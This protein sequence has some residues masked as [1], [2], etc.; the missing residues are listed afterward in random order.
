MGRAYARV[1]P[2]GVCGCVFYNNDHIILLRVSYRGRSRVMFSAIIKTSPRI[3]YII[4]IIILCNMYLGDYFG[5]RNISANDRRTDVVYC[6]PVVPAVMAVRHTHSRAPKRR[7][8]PPH[9]LRVLR[10]V[11]FLLPPPIVRPGTAKDN[12]IKERAATTGALS[13]G[14]ICVSAC[15]RNEITRRRNNGTQRNMLPAVPNIIS[16]IP[17]AL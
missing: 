15:R 5:R 11:F 7:R 14:T 8:P 2:T 17:R 4:T 9:T 1:R 10:A 12:A 13:E 6:R 3:R 16:T